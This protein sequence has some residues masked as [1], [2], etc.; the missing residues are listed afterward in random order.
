M[1]ETAGQLVTRLI[2]DKAA[3]LARPVIAAITGRSLG[4]ALQKRLDDLDTRAQE[5]AESGEQLTPDDPAMI[6]LLAEL[7]K[8]MLANGRAINGAA[9]NTQYQGLIA[10]RDVGS[11]LTILGAGGEE[12]LASIGISWNT[13]STDAIRALANLV[14]TDAWRDG[15]GRYGASVTNDILALFIRGVNPLEASRLIR[16]KVEGLPA[17]YA[18]NMLRTLFLTMSRRGVHATFLA[19]ADIIEYQIRLATLDTRV[20]MSCIALHGTRL[21]PGEELQDHHQGR[22]VAIAKLIGVPAPNIRTGEDWFN[23]LSADEQQ[24]RMGIGA[25][26]AWQDGAIQLRDFVHPYQDALFGP[27]L[28]EASLKEM[29][30]PVA[31][32]YYQR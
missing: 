7:D 15:L 9:E 19:N 17:A 6:A 28:R 5:L 20:C 3:D 18:N 23:G 25:Y 2:K 31:K 8:A 22:C 24:K 14:G 16:E 10:G 27:M 4:A 26:Y 29:L 11:G 21:E 32:A 12:T 13:V 1:A 30:G